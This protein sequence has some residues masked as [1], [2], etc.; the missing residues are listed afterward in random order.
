MLRPSCSVFTCTCSIGSMKC[1]AVQVQVK[2]YNV[3]LYIF[4]P[5][6]SIWIYTCS[7]KFIQWLEFSWPNKMKHVFVLLITRYIYSAISSGSSV[8]R[9]AAH[10]T[11]SHSMPHGCKDSSSLCH[12]LHTAE[13]TAGTPQHGYGQVFSRLGCHTEN[14]NT[15]PG[16]SHNIPSP[17][18]PPTAWGSERRTSETI[19]ISVLLMLTCYRHIIFPDPIRQSL[20]EYVTSSNSLPVSLVCPIISSF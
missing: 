11:C 17:C 18:A 10:R 8:A 13:H 5:I 9:P 6:L 7:I 12:G 14:T 19:S 4:G 1:L 3:C 20:L 2:L 16:H 15:P